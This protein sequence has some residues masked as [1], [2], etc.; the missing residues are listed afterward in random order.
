[1]AGWPPQLV[2]FASTTGHERKALWMGIRHQL[3]GVSFDLH[4]LQTLGVCDDSKP[5]LASW[6]FRCLKCRAFDPTF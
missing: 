6:Q 1:M 2:L 4:S 3:N 5:D